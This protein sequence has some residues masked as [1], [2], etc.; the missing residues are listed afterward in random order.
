MERTFYDSHMHAFNLSHPNLGSFVKRIVLG[1]LNIYKL[2]TILTGV[3]IT[4]IILAKL[5]F[6][7]FLRDAI[8][9][10][11]GVL[12]LTN[13]QIIFTWKI[14]IALISLIIIYLLFHAQQKIRNAFGL[15]YLMDHSIG[16]YFLQ[17]EKDLVRRFGEDV[18]G[19]L[20]LKISGVF[21]D[22]YALSPLMMHFTGDE[23][24]PIRN[25]LIHY[26]LA[27]KYIDEQ[28]VDLFTGIKKYNKDT[29]FHLLKIYPFMGITLNNKSYP[30]IDNLRTVMDKYFGEFEVD[31]REKLLSN[32]FEDFAGDIK[33]L[34][35]Y[36]FAGIK[37]YPPLGF[38]PWP[39][40]LD[41]LEKAQ[42]LFETCESKNIPMITHCGGSGFGVMKKGKYEEYGSPSQ[43]NKILYRYPNLKICFAHFGP[44]ESLF[45][46]NDWMSPIIDLIAD[47]RFPNVY[48][49]ISCRCFSKRDFKRLEKLIEKDINKKTNVLDCDIYNKILYGTD[50]PMNVIKS[51][52]YDKYLDAFSKSHYGAEI[53]TSLC[54]DNPRRFLFEEGDESPLKKPIICDKANEKS[55]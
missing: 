9:F 26:P 43:W 19:E 21:Y 52:S 12:P 54:E 22:K 5:N 18:K 46:K 32:D 47:E 13:N 7:G 10:F 53:K 42:Y 33:K 29:K 40:D 37:V 25:K 36:T 15:A 50:F 51:G 30:K 16:D 31:N 14:F 24:T 2:I 28:T 39:D 4:L 34:N 35:H 11:I 48:T 17:I 38:N 49:D 6:L 41:E 27:K 20:K 45:K 1:K 3:I 55:K 23:N 44:A 8:I